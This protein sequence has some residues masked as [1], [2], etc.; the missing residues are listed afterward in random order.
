MMSAA[1]LYY[2]HLI[3]CEND[4][5]MERGAEHMNEEEMRFILN[6]IAPQAVRDEFDAYVQGLRNCQ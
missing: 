5:L 2:I 1:L 4:R 6:T 3:H